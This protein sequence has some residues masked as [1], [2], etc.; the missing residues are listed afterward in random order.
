L[1]SVFAASRSDELLPALN[2]LSKDAD[3]DVAFAASKAI[4][5][6]QARGTS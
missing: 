5:I 3:P 1:C 2:K 4:R 6:L